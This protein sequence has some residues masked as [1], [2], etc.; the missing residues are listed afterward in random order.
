MQDRCMH[1]WTL[2]KQNT[3]EYTV[4]GCLGIYQMEII[5]FYLLYSYK[6]LF[7]VL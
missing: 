4:S 1:E 3:V 6:N 5:Q 7:V 2:Q